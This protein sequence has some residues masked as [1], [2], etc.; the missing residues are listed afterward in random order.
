MVESVDRSIY[1]HTISKKRNYPNH[2]IHSSF[3]LILTKI[4]FKLNWIFTMDQD[5]FLKNMPESTNRNELNGE[6][7]LLVQPNDI[8][9]F[10]CHLKCCSISC[11]I[12]G[13]VRLVEKKQQRRKP[14]QFH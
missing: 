2:L 14:P 12:I 6:C 3:A 10:L 4:K 13:F 8:D 11:A 5:P 1:R 9:T 7:N